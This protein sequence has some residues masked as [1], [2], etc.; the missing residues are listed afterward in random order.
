LLVDKL[1]IS[2]KM[3]VEG[4]SDMSLHFGPSIVGSVFRPVTQSLDRPAWL[5]TRPV[6]R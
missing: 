6:A 4:S 3:E 2:L 5:I 1:L